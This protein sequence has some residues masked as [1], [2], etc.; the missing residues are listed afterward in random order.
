MIIWIWHRGFL[1]NDWMI[2]LFVCVFFFLD[3]IKTLG[4]YNE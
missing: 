3:R 2:A 4:W 1:F